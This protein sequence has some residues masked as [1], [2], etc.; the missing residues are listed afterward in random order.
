MYQ[1]FFI[2]L[3]QP[4]FISVSG[5]HY[6]R[7]NLSTK[8]TRSVSLY[9]CISLSLFPSQPFTISVTGF[10]SLWLLAFTTRRMVRSA[11]LA[12]I[13]ASLLR[14]LVPFLIYIC[15]RKYIQHRWVWSSSSIQLS[16]TGRLL[17]IM[18]NVCEYRNVSLRFLVIVAPWN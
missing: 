18:H 15:T 8:F 1:P 11:H 6:I 10:L 4:F 12:L 2:Y 3:Y 13:F 9:I 16:A 7:I 5:F 14:L 17:D